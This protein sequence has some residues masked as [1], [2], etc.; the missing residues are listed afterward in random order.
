MEYNWF[1]WKHAFP[2]IKN[3]RSSHLSVDQ[4]IY[5]LIVSDVLVHF[6]LFL[7]QKSFISVLFPFQ[8]VFTRMSDS[9]SIKKMLRS[10]LQSSKAGV[11]MSSLQSE[12]RSLCGE[13]IPLK[14]L[15]YS[16]LED[17]LRSIPSVV[18]LE[19]H[20][21]EVRNVCWFRFKVIVSPVETTWYVS[22]Y[23]HLASSQIWV[24]K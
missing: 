17:Y 10:V 15:G 12:Y 23:R 19:Y 7:M 22:V 5:T 16:D 24:I 13:S 4:A 2:G 11:S 6:I 3:Y 1:P 14:K 9:E 8:C 20:M 21:G 18:R